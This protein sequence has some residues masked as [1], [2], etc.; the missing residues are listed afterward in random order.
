MFRL[1]KTLV[2][3]ATEGDHGNEPNAV[4]IKS[5]R[6]GDDT[7]YVEDKGGNERNTCM[8]TST[9][10]IAS[11]CVAVVVVAGVEVVDAREVT[12]GVD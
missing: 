6:A 1:T 11:S 7:N 5:D 8:S 12:G 3:N 2:S 9:C 10:I 4:I